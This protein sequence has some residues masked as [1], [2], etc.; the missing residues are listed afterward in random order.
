MTQEPPY[1]LMAVDFGKGILRQFGMNPIS[2]RHEWPDGP[3][4]SQ[5]SAEEVSHLARALLEPD[6]KRWYLIEM[7]DKEPAWLCAPASNTRAT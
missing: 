1:K 6:Q 7:Q 3:A 2:A 5:E 4:E